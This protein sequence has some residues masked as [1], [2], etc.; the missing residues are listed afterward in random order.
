VRRARL[1]G[2]I[3]VA[4]MLGV[5]LFGW[6][7]LTATWRL[8]GDTTSYDLA[9]GGLTGL[10]LPAAF[11]AGAP[12][13]ALAGSAAYA[14]AGFAGGQPRY[15]ALGVAT[16]VAALLL[17]G[18]PR[19]RFAPRPSLAA[20]AVLATPAF[21][22]LGVHATSKERAHITDEAHAGFHAW[23]GVAAFAFAA[24]AVGW[25]AAIGVDRRVGAWTV[26]SAVV[27]FGIGCIVYPA[28]AASV[29][30]VLGALAVVWGSGMVAATEGRR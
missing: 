4:G 13:V 12:S 8:G 3:V 27:Y 23:A 19:L 24:C 26:G 29:G 6:I 17:L 21:L 15:V 28:A 16:A 14:L 2:R 25:L 11:L 9:Y 22:W 18:R 20:L 7:D 5:A 30:R 10:M 1:A